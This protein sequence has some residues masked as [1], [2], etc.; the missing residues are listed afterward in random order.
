MAGEVH[1][2]SGA[3]APGPEA[4]RQR[5]DGALPNPGA[6]HHGVGR[7]SEPRLPGVVFGGLSRD[8]PGCQEPDQ[9][10]PEEGNHGSDAR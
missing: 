3:Y 6:V 1:G 8:D 2:P 7:P 9:D 4:S 10:R 5:H